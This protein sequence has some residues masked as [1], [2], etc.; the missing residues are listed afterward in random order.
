[1]AGSAKRFLSYNSKKG[2]GRLNQLPKAWPRYCALCALPFTN[3][4]FYS[5]CV[6]NSACL[7]AALEHSPGK[8]M[9]HTCQS[10]CFPNSSYAQS[11]AYL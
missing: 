1:M 8:E 2:L 7:V 4:C 3:R 10:P 6:M 9:E 5:V 11:L